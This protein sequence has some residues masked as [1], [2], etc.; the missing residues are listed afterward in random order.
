MKIHK[1][2]LHILIRKSPR[3]NRVT[4]AIQWVIEKLNTSQGKPELEKVFPE[5]GLLLVA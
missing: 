5:S 2:G 3:I 4:R 1:I